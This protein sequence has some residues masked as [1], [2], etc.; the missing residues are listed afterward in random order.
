MWNCNW[1]NIGGGIT[2]TI[3]VFDNYAVRYVAS[4]TGQ[5]RYINP[6]LAAVKYVACAPFPVKYIAEA[7]GAIKYIASPKL[8]IIYQCKQ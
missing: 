2:N 3:R 5:V 8:K 7:P 6:A 1:Y 4:P